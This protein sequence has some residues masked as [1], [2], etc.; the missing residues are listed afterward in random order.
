VARK[1]KNRT[2]KGWKDFMMRW[3]DGWTLAAWWRIF[4]GYFIRAVEDQ[5]WLMEEKSVMLAFVRTESGAYYYAQSTFVFL[6]CS[7]LPLMQ[8][9]ILLQLY[10]S[11]MMECFAVFC[12]LDRERAT[13]MHCMLLW[14]CL[15]ISGFSSCSK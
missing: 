9:C 13:I 11:V 10:L 12:V 4:G 1:D 14:Y 5:G 15:I 8:Q 2:N 3:F 7:C 6:S